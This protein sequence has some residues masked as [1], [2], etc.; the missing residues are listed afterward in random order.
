MPWTCPACHNLIR[1]STDLP[2]RDRVYCC[3]VC[4]GQ[5]MFDLMILKMRPVPDG[6]D[7]DTEKSDA[8]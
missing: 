5:M 3:P 7:H 2:R 8:A 6:H 1:H 4:R